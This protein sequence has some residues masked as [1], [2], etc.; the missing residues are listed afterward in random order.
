MDISWADVNSAELLVAA[1]R[2][3]FGLLIVLKIALSCCS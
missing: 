2:V 1:L 3:R